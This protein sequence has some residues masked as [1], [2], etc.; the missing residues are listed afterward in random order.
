MTQIPHLSSSTGYE[1]G[2]MR[3]IQALSKICGDRG[4][5]APHDDLAAVVGVARPRPQSCQRHI[6][7]VSAQLR[8]LLN[9]GLGLCSGNR[10]C[11]RR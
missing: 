8:A 1:L 10:P 2:W 4:R 6:S 3:T 9:Q 5:A 7:D 11:G